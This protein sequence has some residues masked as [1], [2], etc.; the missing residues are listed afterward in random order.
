M[1]ATKYSKRILDCLLCSEAGDADAE[2]VSSG[3]T[4]A[5]NAGG[6]NRLSSMETTAFA[7]ATK[8]ACGPYYVDP[9]ANPTGAVIDQ[10]HTPHTV[11]FPN[12]YIALFTEAPTYT[13]EGTLMYTEVGYKWTVGEGSER[14]EYIPIPE[15]ETNYAGSYHRIPL[16]TT[17]VDGMRIM[18]NAEQFI[19]PAATDSSHGKSKIHNQQM[20]VFPEC[21]DDSWGTIVAFGI[22]SGINW[23]GGNVPSGDEGMGEL[24]FW[25]TIQS[26]DGSSD[27]VVVSTGNVPIIRIGDFEVTLG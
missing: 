27:S 15:G 7:E 17:G 25:D 19:D 20:I 18:A 22:W 12:A 4:G 14:G 11:I 3:L 13:E 23:E 16:R 2:R 1:L 6:I 5:T 26:A 10:G 24:I 9:A 8:K 21:T